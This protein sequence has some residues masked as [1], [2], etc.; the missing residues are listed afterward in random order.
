MSYRAFMLAA[1]LLAAVTVSANAADPLPAVTPAAPVAGDAKI[2]IPQQ[3][4]ASFADLADQLLPSVVNISTTQILNK[5]KDGDDTQALPDLP[6][7]PP[8]SPFEDFFKDFFERNKQG[9]G[10]GAPRRATSLGSGF[11]IDGSGM[12]VTNNHV[13]EDADEITV[14]LHDNTELKAELIGRDTKTDIALLRVK[15]AKPLPAVTWG[16]SDGM[17]VGDW[18]LAIGN[19]F[20]LGGTVTQGIISARARDINAGPYDD[21]IQTDASINRGNSGGPM[22][23][24]DGQVIGINTAIFSP[25][26]GSVGIGFAIPANLAK[27]VV[28]QLKDKGKITRGWIGVRIQQVTDDIAKSL[29]LPKTEGALVSSVTAKGPAADAGVKNGDVIIKFNGRDVA[30]MRRLPR[31]VAETNI[32]AKVPVT[33]WRDGK[34]LELTMK[35]AELPADLADD[36]QEQTNKEEKADPAKAVNI[37]ALGLKVAVLTPALRQRYELDDRTK[38]VVIVDI[39][40]ASDAAAKGLQPGDVIVEAAQTEV[41]DPA[42]LDKLAATAKKSGKPI[43]LLVERSGDARFVAVATTEAKPAEKKQ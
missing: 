24:L 18:V 1:I 15:P 43:L 6:T 32:G 29:G 39:N 22:F 42:D 9:N 23:N 34:A 8:G 36:K 31:V 40:N 11:I 17:R 35:V 37:D 20:G 5:Q 25:S 33:V 10:G 14:I 19:P 2:N 30:E 41:K 13:I 4:P 27:N 16:D 7:F 26:G 3:H 21:F 28:A 12:I 38:G